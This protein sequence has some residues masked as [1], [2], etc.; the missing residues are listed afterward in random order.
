MKLLRALTNSRK[1]QATFIGLVTA[2]FG[3]RAGISADQV[4]NAVMLLVAYVVGQGITD[5][6]SSYAKAKAGP[7][8][9]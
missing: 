4:T 3:E 2:L 9:K 5:A 7:A 1:V 8:K 6:G